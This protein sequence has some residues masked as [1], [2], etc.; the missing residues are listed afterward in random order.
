MELDC[1]M[2]DDNCVEFNDIADIKYLPIRCRIKNSSGGYNFYNFTKYGCWIDDDKAKCVIYPKG[3]TTWEGFVPPCKFKDGDV[4]VAEDNESFQ[5]FLLKHLTHSK[6]ANDYDGDCYFGWDFQCD[7][8]FEKGNWGFNRLAT[9][10]E[11]ERLFQTIKENGYKWNAETKTLDKLI[12]PKFKVG[13][14]IKKKGL[15]NI[16]AIEIATVGQTIYTIKNGGGFL[17]IET[18]DK[19]YELVT[20]K[21]DINTL[22]PFESRVLVRNSDSGFWKP[23]F[24]GVYEAE[25]SN[26]HQYRNY[27]T[28]E[29]FVRCC[30]PYNDET[31]HLIGKTI[32]CPEYYKT[33]EE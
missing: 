26:E 23:A 11:K 4:V 5:L 24:W 8:L 6:N 31:K 18:T 19:N 32:D 30:I 14:R 20:N 1:T 16:Y 12:V 29:G 15:D 21:F 28:T 22:V 10:E 2:F 17:Y 7:E 25:K 3:K 9:E 13:D 33:W 27:L